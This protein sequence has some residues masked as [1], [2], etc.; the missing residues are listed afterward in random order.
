MFQF[1]GVILFLTTMFVCCAS[2]LLP[3]ES[4]MSAD[5][6]SIGWHFPGGAA[7]S[8]PAYSAQRAVTVCMVTAV[9]LGI[10]LASL[11]LGLQATRRYAPWGAVAVTGFAMVFWIIHLVFVVGVLEAVWLTV[12]A[13][14]L[15]VLFVVLFGLSIA[16]LREM[17]RDPPPS[18]QEVL[19]EG[20][21][22]PY[23]HLHED[24]PEVRLAA[25]LAQ[26][27]ERLAVQQ[28]ELEM[29]EEELRRKASQPSSGESGDAS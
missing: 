20:Y 19:P 2:A 12:V 10:A 7:D 29:L 17:L 9:F 16:S 3:K 26:R 22:I 13:G 18:R 8:A 6:Q 4:A 1:V 14:A 23:S 11:G 21:K 28:K 25:E 27:R 15:T 24:P 5:W